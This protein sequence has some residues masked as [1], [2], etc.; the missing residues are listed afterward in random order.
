LLKKQL[1]KQLQVNVII[2]NVFLIY[3]VV[4]IYSI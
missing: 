1:C 4:H 2:R 3:T